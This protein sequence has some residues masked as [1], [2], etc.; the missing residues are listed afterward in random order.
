MKTRIFLAILLLGW[1]FPFLPASAEV[2]EIPLESGVGKV[3]FGN[4]AHM[5][6]SGI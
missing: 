1:L 5:V 3:E 2:V 6:L 4:P